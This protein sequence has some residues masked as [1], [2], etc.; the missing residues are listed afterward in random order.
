[1]LSEF[2]GELQVVMSVALLHSVVQEH[3]KRSRDTMIVLSHQQTDSRI[4]S[5]CHGS[6]S[7]APYL[8]VVAVTALPDRCYCGCHITAWGAH[9]ASLSIIQHSTHG[10]ITPPLRLSSQ[11]LLIFL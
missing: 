2:A 7:H 9:T 1:M 4:P 10:F 3:G 8:V 11:T 6:A 5:L